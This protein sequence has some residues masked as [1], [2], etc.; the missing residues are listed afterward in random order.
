MP[1]PR[2][3]TTGLALVV[4]ASLA[5]HLVTFLIRPVASYRVLALG[6][7]ATAVGLVAAAGA[8]LP[9]FL[10]L[11]MGRAA[12]RGGLTWLLAGGGLAMTAGALGLA[13]T[14]TLPLMAAGNVVIGVGQLALMLAFQGLVAELSPPEHQDRNFG[15][16]TAAAS[17][18]QLIGPLTGGWVIGSATAS[19]MVAETRE[20]FLLATAV[21]VVIT[22]LCLALAWT[23]KALARNKKNGDHTVHKGSAR[24]LLGNRRLLV[25]IFTSFAV[26]SSVD[27]IT[28]YLPVLGEDRGLSP[29]VVG[30]LLA[31]RAGFSFLSRLLIPLLVGRFGRLAV[32][33]VSGGLAGICV[34]ALVFTSGFWPLAALMA[35]LGLV[36]GL[37]QPLT[38]TWTVREAPDNLRS[39][40]LGLRL[41]G[42]RVAQAAAPA[43]AGAISG[44][45]GVAG[46]FLLIAL[47]LFASTVTVLP[48][49]RAERG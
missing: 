8:L 23:L 33:S 9:V 49:W 14:T 18:G 5:V 21:G 3:A 44:L 34:T 39:T 35:V 31:V 25:A 12:D 28:A 37:G 27:V 45:V 20:A 43:A 17:I 10:A 24:A 15:W 29:A 40:A 19:A 41:T 47:L 7:D 6:G 32:L 26:M 4:T 30:A 36:L 1:V 16:F 46:P 11:P 22:L 2:P 13:F 48:G 42:N 38:M